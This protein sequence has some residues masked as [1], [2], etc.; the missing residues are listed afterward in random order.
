MQAPSVT[1]VRRSDRVCLT[2]LLEASGRDAEGK[3]FVEPARTMLISRH[4]GVI[5]LKRNLATGQEVHLRRTLPEEAHR[6]AITRV[7]RNVGSQTG[8]HTGTQ[9]SGAAGGAA[10]AASGLTGGQM[11]S[12]ECVDPNADLWGVEFPA[13][14]GSQEFVARMLLECSFCGSREVVYLNEFELGGFEKNRGTA[15]HCKV[16]DVPTIWTQ[17]PHEAATVDPVKYAGSVHATGVAAASGAIRNATASGANRDAAAGGANKDVAARRRW[18]S[19]VPP[20][21]AAGKRC[22]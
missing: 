4:G 10:Q 7:I 11:Y 21:R 2:L 9:S 6:S 19:H 13:L 20:T 3:E 14:E 1:S 15:R 8:A 5:V 17:A 12:V 22:A 18:N 16:C